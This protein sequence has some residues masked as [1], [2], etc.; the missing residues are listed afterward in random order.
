MQETE[1]SEGNE[2]DLAAAGEAIRRP[3]NR[4]TRERNNKISLWQDNL[5]S[6]RYNISQF[7]LACAGVYAPFVPAVRLLSN[8]SLV[9]N[10]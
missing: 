6:G 2:L 3:R 9:L 10:K 5:Q 4:A 1:E 8:I 7:L